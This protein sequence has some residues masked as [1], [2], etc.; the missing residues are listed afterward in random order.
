MTTASTNQQN[1]REER[2]W[3]SAPVDVYEGAG[4]YLVF[5]DIPGV[6][7][8]DV[9]MEFAQG[10]LRIHAGEYRRVFTI[11]SDVDVEKISADLA[12]GVLQVH[13]PKLESAK[14]RQI[15]IRST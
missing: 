1:G 13:L 12:N 7:K 9:E 5:A 3:A 6:K 8:E 15:K 10:E 4:E 14:P 2:A 11:G